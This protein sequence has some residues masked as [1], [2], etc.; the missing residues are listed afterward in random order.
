MARL[1]KNRAGTNSVGYMGQMKKTMDV[2]LSTM[3]FR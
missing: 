1:L 3:V 2:G